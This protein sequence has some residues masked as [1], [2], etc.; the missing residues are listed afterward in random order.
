MEPPIHTETLVTN[1][2]LEALAVDNGGSA[3]VVLLLGDPHLLE[4]GEGGQ[5]GATDPY[6]VLS[7]GGSD[8]LDLDGG[9]S[10]GGDFLLHT[11][12]DTG[13]HGGATG[14]DGVGVQ[15]LTDVNVALH[16]GVE[17]GLVDAAGLHFEEGRLEEALRATEPLVSDGDDL[18]VG[19]L[20]GLLKGGA[21]GGGGHLLL[22]IEGDVAQLLLDVP[23]DLALGGGG[24]GVSP[25]GEDLHQ[26][27]GEFT[28]SQV[29]PEDGVGKGITLVDGDGVRDTISGVHDDTGGT[30]GSVQGQDSLDGDVHGGHVEGLEHDLGHLLPVG[31]GVEGSLS[32]KHGL[33][34]GGNAE[35]VVE[36]VMPDLLHI[37]PVGDDSV[38]DGVLEG[39]DTSLGLGL[40]T[41]IGVLLSHTDHDSLVTGTAD[42]GGEDSAGSVISGETGLAHAGAV[43]NYQSSY[44]LVTHLLSGVLNLCCRLP[45]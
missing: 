41:D 11:V 42:D 25:L 6:G 29:E 24:E 44:V 30:A 2:S 33:L 21:G 28:A 13:V 32:Q 16:D 34:L 14:H 35:L 43:V 36:G 17:G 18:S 3:L 40:V 26:V 7:L 15:V 31:L 5:D 22:E 8:D 38:L 9:G 45:E 1:N 10:Q 4:G 12:S 37:V 39:E 20:V 27:V 23:H 19:K